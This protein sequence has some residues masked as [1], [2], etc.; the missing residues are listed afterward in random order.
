MAVWQTFPEDIL[1]YVTSSHERRGVAAD[2]GGLAA[3][4]QVGLQQAGHH[5]RGQLTRSR[6][7]HNP[8]SARA[9][10]SLQFRGHQTFIHHAKRRHG[11]R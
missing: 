6:R 10:T 5:R 8:T 3:C 9:H 7:Q 2:G 11:L 4:F 1:S